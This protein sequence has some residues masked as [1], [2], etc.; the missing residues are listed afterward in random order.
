MN[1]SSVVQDG[2][3]KLSNDLESPNTNIELALSRRISDA[4]ILRRST[5]PRIFADHGDLRLAS[6]EQPHEEEDADGA[7]TISKRQLSYVSIHE[8]DESKA[9]ISEFVL[10]DGSGLTSD[11]HKELLNKWGPNVLPEKH[12]PAW[13][14]FLDQMVQ[15]MPIGIW[16][17]AIILAIIESWP[18]VGILVFLNF[19]NASIAFYESMKAGDAV[20][21]LKAS[22]KPIA[23]VKRDGE[24]KRVNAA[25]V[26]P[27]DLVQLN[28]GAT[29]PADVRLHGDEI[30]IDQSALTGESLPVTM[31]RRDQVKMG[32]TVARGE[33]E[34]TVEFTGARTYFGKTASLLTNTG[35]VSNLQMLLV[36]VV[37]Y[38]SVLSF[39]MCTSAFIYL[40]V[41]PD[42]VPVKKAL[43]FAVVL[44]VASIP[45]AMEIVVTTSLALGS[46]S[47]SSQGAIC[48]RLTSIEDLACMEI[49]CSDK[50]GTLTTNQMELQPNTPAYVEGQDT[51]SILRYAAMA[52]KWKEPPRDALDTLI[53]QNVDLKSLESMEQLS[54]MPFDPVYKRTEGSIRDT[55]TG[56]TFR[57]AKGAPHIILKLCSAA[58]FE[59]ALVKHQPES[60]E[61]AIVFA[62]KMSSSADF[63]LGSDTGDNIVAPTG[64][65][66]V[67][68]RVEHDVRVLGH[69][70]IRCL[71]V[72]RTVSVPTNAPELASKF[73]VDEHGQY[74]QFLGLLTFLDPPRHDTAETIAN[75][76]KLGVE[77]KMITGDHLLIAREMA[78]RIHLGKNILNS[79]G[80]PLLGEN[81]KVPED[82]AE[83]YGN[84]VLGADG[85]A[86]TFPEHKFLIVECLRALGYKV[87][88]TGD[89]VNDAPALKTSDVG[90]AVDGATDAAKAA[91]DLVLTKPGLS[92][93][94]HGVSLARCIFSRIRN[95]L[96]YRCAATL[97]L[98]FFFFIGVFAFKPN[99]YQV[100]QPAGVEEEQ[101][102]DF[103]SLPVLFLMLITVLNDGTLIS[104]AYDNAT[105]KKSPEH[106]NLNAMFFV[107]SVL[108]AVACA[109]SLLLLWFCLDSWNPSG[110][111]QGIGLEGLEYGQVIT[112]IFLKVAISDFLTLFSARAGEDWIWFS[113]PAN[114]L[115]LAAGA[116]LL[117]S[118][119]IAVGF[120][121]AMVD[122]LHVL[123][124]GRRVPKLLALWI[125]LYC[126]FFFIVQDAA[127]V[128]CYRLLNKYQIFNY[129][130]EG[131]HVETPDAQ[132]SNKGTSTT[133]VSVL[134]GKPS[135]H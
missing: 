61:G 11:Q 83:K 16:I 71:A 96:L 43:S 129:N 45:L 40:L 4:D 44:L 53:L 112:A 104:I 46:K 131:A 134:L 133:D 52:A 59:P 103:F 33:S 30:D 56:Q 135:S 63:S 36:K 101:W 42:P 115:I 108:A 48:T 31:Y 125:W 9:S 128:G 132:H 75:A 25:E 120:P 99:E 17:C 10:N 62:R 116:S 20:A 100:W 127:K 54:Q 89:G 18:D 119:A 67:A 97:Q 32:S 3:K 124:L 64:Y 117:I 28:A 13:L 58:A 14:I 70:G 123:G 110:V 37:L 76:H 121:S 106:W 19:A 8:Q 34:A 69:K 72:A 24:W 15:P 27:G 87:G 39:I 2:D 47:L 7:I 88:M 79:K 118:T 38:L 86:E 50:T 82:L 49:L 12:R 92:T 5:E 73:E 107:S 57:T 95:F 126:I 77:V 26:V 114:I 51:A 94:V 60:N 23:V 1:Y 84:M 35:S 80:L 111:F 113:R 122:D 93:I 66:S 6:A 22:L 74:W 85:F 55:T 130:H 68:Q 91:A 90:I 78:K 102:P 21:A 105:P 109:S 29:V 65:V 98:L 81:S 41:K